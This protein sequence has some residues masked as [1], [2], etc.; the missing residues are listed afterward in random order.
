MG[1]SINDPAIPVGDVSPTAFSLIDTGP[2]WLL[3]PRFTEKPLGDNMWIS[4]GFFVLDS[5]VFR[6]IEN[7]QT[8]WERGPLEKLAARGE[9]SAF[10]HSGFWYPVDTLRDK[11]HLEALWS[12]GRAP[13]K[14]WQ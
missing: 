9:L 13:W 12:S 6:C 7:D 14:T 1:G 3:F 2:E 10:R 8:V 5:S 11:L 4:G